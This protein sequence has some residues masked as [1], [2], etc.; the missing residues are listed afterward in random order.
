MERTYDLYLM[1]CVAA[2]GGGAYTTS[3]RARTLTA[4]TLRDALETCRR[5]IEENDTYLA[6]RFPAVWQ[7]VA[8]GVASSWRIEWVHGTSAW[9]A[10]ASDGKVE[11]CTFP[12]EVGSCGSQWD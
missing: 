2:P 7:S 8:N 9:R 10:L 11:V 12:N 4:R 3:R 6:A 1:D 5:D